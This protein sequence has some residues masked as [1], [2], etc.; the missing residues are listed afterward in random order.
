M[1]IEEITF[2]GRSIKGTP[3]LS[4]ALNSAQ[5]S[6]QSVFDSLPSDEQLDFFSG[7]PTDS[8]AAW[9]GIVENHGG[10]SDNKAIDINLSTNPY[11][12]TR[13]GDVFGGE[14]EPGQLLAVRQRAVEVCDRATQFF[15][16]ADTFADIAARRPGEST[17]S[18]YARFQ[19]A[20][21]N[22]VS[23]LS[24]AFNSTLT[25][26][27]RAPGADIEALSEQDLVLQLSGELRAKDVAMADLQTF[28]QSPEFLNVNPSHPFSAR[29]QYWRILRDYEH[30]R[31]P[32][33]AGIASAHPGKTRNPLKGF[34]NFRVDLA[35]AL[36]DVSM[37]RWGACDFGPDFNGDMMHFDIRLPRPM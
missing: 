19:A 5:D 31:I 22:L 18:V 28:M 2:L 6:L 12:A 16:G 10:H 29:E 23:Y 25:F 9:C 26:I 35:I 20:S 1:A 15:L 33:V 21:E 24:F 34:L 27:S 37:M 32:M 7:Q 17:A 14:G 11:I 3:Q 30:V 13:T 8:V 4:A 36:C